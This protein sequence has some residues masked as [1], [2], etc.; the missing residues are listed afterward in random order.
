MI[1]APTQGAGRPT[2]WLKNSINGGP[3][4]MPVTPYGTAPTP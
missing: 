1:A 2:T 4:A 3:S